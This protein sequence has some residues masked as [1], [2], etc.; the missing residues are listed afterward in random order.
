MVG[1]W[2]GEEFLVILSH[3]G[4]EEVGRTAE[5]MRTLVQHS[6]LLFKGHRTSVTVSIGAA[7]MRPGENYEQLL[8]RADQ[9]TYESKRLGRNRS[10]LATG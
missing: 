3:A 4:L 6:H 1:R 10:T 7:S 5:R 8:E 9:A 2:G